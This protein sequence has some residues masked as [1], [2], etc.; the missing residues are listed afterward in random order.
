MDDIDSF[1]EKN[2]EIAITNQVLKR[3]LQTRARHSAN[4]LNGITLD[5]NLMHLAE[6]FDI[7]N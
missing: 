4:A 1:N 6:E 5:Q 3:S 7:A 2:P